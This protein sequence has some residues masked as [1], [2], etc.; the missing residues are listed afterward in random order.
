MEKSPEEM[1]KGGL[2]YE[3]KQIES[4]FIYSGK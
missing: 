3:S 2:I 4:V 1:L